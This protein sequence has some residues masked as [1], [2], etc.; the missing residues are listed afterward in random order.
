MNVK[1]KKETE[2]ITIY[3]HRIRN[4]IN[5]LNLSIE[6][7]EMDENVDKEILETLKNSLKK[8]ANELKISII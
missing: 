4:C 7:L 3:P 2:N 6:F 1:R 5:S 8:L